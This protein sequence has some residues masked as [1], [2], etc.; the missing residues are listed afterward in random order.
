MKRNFFRVYLK[1]KNKK[2]IKEKVFYINCREKR[3]N[4][5][6]IEN[7]DEVCRGNRL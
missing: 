3:L 7:F 2:I 6:L 5:W 4:I 1:Y